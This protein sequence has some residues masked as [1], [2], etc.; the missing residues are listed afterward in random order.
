MN[1]SHHRPKLSRITFHKVG[2]AH[3]V[4]EFVKIVFRDVGDLGKAIFSRAKWLLNLLP[5]M[6]PCFVVY[7]FPLSSSRLKHDFGS[8]GRI[9]LTGRCLHHSFT[10][11]AR[12]QGHAPEETSAT[13]VECSA[14]SY[15]QETE[16]KA[17]NGM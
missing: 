9:D 11:F 6:C 2:Q 4:L 7:F 14:G 15:S 16:A 5:S 1:H 12:C 13:C 10:T 3:L 17:P 8:S